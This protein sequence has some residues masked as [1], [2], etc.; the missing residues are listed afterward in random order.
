MFQ[1]TSGS[2]R[3][4]NIV[5]HNFKFNELQFLHAGNFKLF[6]TTSDK[7]FQTTSDKLFQTTLGYF[8]QIQIVLDNLRLF[9]QLQLPLFQSTY[10]H[11]LDRNCESSKLK[12]ESLPKLISCYN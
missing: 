2:F 5:L 7:L 10:M 12:L 8:N 4:R 11:S 3:Q 6:Q 1:T 9:K